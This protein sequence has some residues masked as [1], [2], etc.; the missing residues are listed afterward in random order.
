M[1]VTREYDYALRIVRALATSNI[2]ENVSEICEAEII[3]QAY[4]YKIL[5]KL[6][7]ANIV[8]AQRGARGGYR[9][10]ANP[11]NLTLFDVYVAIEGRLYINECLVEG[12]DCP[13]MRDNKPCQ[14]HIAL[15]QIQ[16]NLIKDLKSRILLDILT[17]KVKK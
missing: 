17:E 8:K 13:N 4:A 10:V 5:K 6:E 11:A 12:Y 7:K 2:Q 14:V 15:E 1:L 16:E 3:P 9:L